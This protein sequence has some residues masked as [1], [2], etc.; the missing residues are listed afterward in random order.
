MANVTKIPV[1]NFE[2]IEDTSKFNEDLTKSYN[3]QSDE[4]YF[5]KVDIKY[6][7]ELHELHNDLPFLPER[8]ETE[9]LEESLIYIIKVII[10]FT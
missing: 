4:G 10:L 2:W 1:N 8:M 7:E 5:H 6:L 3:E 9:K